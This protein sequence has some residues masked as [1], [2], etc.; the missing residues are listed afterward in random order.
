MLSYQH[1]YH[2]GNF[3]DVH[4]HAIYALVLAYFATKVAHSLSSG[5]AIAVVLIPF[6]FFFVLAICFAVVVAAALI[7]IMSN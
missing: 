1:G 3:A 7:P 4:K 5:R 2:A 6:I